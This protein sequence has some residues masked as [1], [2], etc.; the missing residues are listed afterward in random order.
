[1]V[2]L[3]ERGFLSFIAIENMRAK[4]CPGSSR[5]AAT[6]G[7]A[8]ASQQPCILLDATL[9]LRKAEA[10]RPPDLGFLDTPTSVLR[11]VRSTPNPAARKLGLLIP[12]NMRVPE[13]SVIHE[14]F[15]LGGNRS[16]IEDLNWWTASSG[17]VLPS[18]R[19]RVEARSV[20]DRVDALV[21]I[22]K[23]HL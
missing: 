14:V 1:M 13:R 16:A 11:A 5:Q 9:A 21:T 3:H 4:L 17:T 15:R 20:R 6:I 7:F 10:L 18:M 12:R 22:P 23:G 8:M 2:Q 19:I